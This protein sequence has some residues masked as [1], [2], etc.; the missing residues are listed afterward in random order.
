MHDSREA[1]IVVPMFVD[2]MKRVAAA[3]GTT[4]MMSQG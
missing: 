3:P 4:V 1:N 2:G